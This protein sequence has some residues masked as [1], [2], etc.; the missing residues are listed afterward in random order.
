MMNGT[1]KSGG[2]FAVISFFTN[3][4]MGL[5]LPI[6]APLC[7]VLWGAGAGIL[8]VQWDDGATGNTPAK[9]GAF[10]GGIA[11]IG[12]VIGLMIGAIVSF[13]FLGG[14][15]AAAELTRQFGVEGVDP[16]V[17]AASQWTGAIFSGCCIG[18]FNAGVM[19]GIG[20]LAAN[21]YSANQNKAA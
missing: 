18:L 14:A 7:G 11:G 5:L 4:G 21:L 13:A 10:A 16:S 9:N 15:D 8:S 20:A 19:A 3:L 17:M 12:G 1:T 6:C 2:L